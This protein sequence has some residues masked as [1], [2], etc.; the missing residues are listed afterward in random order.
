MSNELET[1]IAACDKKLSELRRIDP[2][3]R[4]QSAGVLPTPACGYSMLK[5][6]IN[7]LAY[8]DCL[9]DA[10][11]SAPSPLSLPLSG[12]PTSQGIAQAVAYIQKLKKW[13]E[14]ELQKQA[15]HHH[16]GET[17]LPADGT[18]VEP[19]DVPA[20]FREGGR[21]G[22]KILTATYLGVEPAW[23]ITSVEL[24]KAYKEKQMTHRIKVGR[25]FAYLFKE[26]YALREARAARANG[27]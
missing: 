22:G 18:K 26:L 16:D 19:E 11:E 13:A 4:W 5:S 9:I 14:A 27:S 10:T 24:T 3:M 20:A 15:P 7:G 23:N 25:S 17:A 12:I 21:S 8:A 1:L 6:A 2:A